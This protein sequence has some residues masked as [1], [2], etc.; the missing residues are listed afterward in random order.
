[1]RNAL[2]LALLTL[3][4]GYTILQ[5]GGTTAQEWAFTLVATCVLSFFFWF[6]GQQ[7]TAPPL[8]RTSSILACALP[9]ARYPPEWARS[10][11]T[12]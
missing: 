11:R 12:I 5:Y 2:P 6:P 4:V 10:T 7:F 1:M 3:I 9:S 8:S